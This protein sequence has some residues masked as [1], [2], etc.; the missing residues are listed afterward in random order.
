MCHPS[1]LMG[2]RLI[3]PKEQFVHSNSELTYEKVWLT[4]RPIKI[5]HGL[6]Q[7]RYQH[8]VVL[9]FARLKLKSKDAIGS[10]KPWC[11]EAYFP[12]LAQRH[13]GASS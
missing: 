12:P 13:R 7:M 10:V 6:C 8:A 3:V 11:P 1:E 5:M 2:L 4:P 9:A